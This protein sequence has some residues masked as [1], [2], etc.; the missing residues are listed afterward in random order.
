MAMDTLSESISIFFRKNSPPGII[1]L[2]RIH[3][4]SKESAGRD[5][6]P[7][8]NSSPYKGIC[9]QGLFFRDKFIPIQR[10]PLAGI[11]FLSQIHPH[12]K[13]FTFR[14]YFLSMNSSPYKGIHRQ[15]LFPRAESIPFRKN[16]PPWML[17]EYRRHPPNPRK[18]FQDAWRPE[19]ASGKPR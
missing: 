9:P 8:P 18:Q 14:D 3:P 5:Y 16:S 13:E 7:E 17:W 4:H 19:T 15:G 6:F 2:G 1:F 11:I 12:S 10:N